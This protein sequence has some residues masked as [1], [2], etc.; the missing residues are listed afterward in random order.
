MEHTKTSPPTGSPNDGGRIYDNRKIAA[1]LYWG[2]GG[3]NN[4]FTDRN[5]GIV[6]TSLVLSE[7]YTGVPKGTNKPGY[8]ELMA[9]AQA[10]DVPDDTISFSS[11]SVNSSIVG[12]E[13]RSETIIFNGDVTNTVSFI[14]PAE[15]TFV[16]QT[17]AQT[18]TGGSVTIKGGDSFYLSAP[19]SYDSNYYS[20]ELKG[21][22]KGYA[23]ILYTM[24]NSSLQTLVKGGQSDSPSPISFTVHYEARE[25]WIEVSKAGNNTDQFIQGA[26]Y[27]ILDSSG[28]VVDTITTGANGK[29]KSKG[30]MPGDYSVTEVIAPPGYTIDQTAQ[31][32]T[33]I[34][35]ETSACT[36][37]NKVV[38]GRVNLKK[39]DTKTG[40][41]PQGSATLVG[42]KYGIYS[43][44]VCT[45]LIEELTIGSDL[46]ATSKP[47]E[48]GASRTVYVKETKA[49]TGY[50]IDPTVYPVVLSQEDAVTE[51]VLVNEIVKDEVITGNIELQ[52]F[53]SEADGESAMLHPEQGAEFTAYDEATG[54]QY[55]EPVTTDKNGHATFN[56]L[57]YG[58]Y[59][60]KQTKTP[61][62][63]IEVD[64]FRVNIN[65]NGTT[66]YYN[67]I[68]AKFTSLVK[69]I[70]VDEET[71]RTIPVANTTFKIRDLET[72][73]WVT[74]TVNY[75]AQVV[76]DEFKTNS[77]GELILPLPLGYGEYE[78]HE[79]AA[80]N[81]YVLS[82]EP[83]KFTVNEQN[84]TAGEIIEVT[85]SDRAQK[86]V[87]TLTK[88][89]DTLSGA[90]KEKTKY[91]DQ[92]NFIFNQKALKDAEFDFV[93]AEDIL[94]P[95]GTVRA[96]K[97]DVVGHGVT[98]SKG[99][100]KSP[101]LYLGQYYAV[102]TKAPAGMV[103]TG[104]QIPFELKYA[105][106][107]VAITST[108]V[109]AENVL[110]ELQILINKS[111][112]SVAYEN[113][114]TVV[115][116]T[117][118]NGKTFGVFARDAI[119]VD[120]EEIVPA[121]GLLAVAT[122]KEG[123]A[124]VKD[125]FPE[126]MYYVKELETSS[127]HDLNTN[128]YDFVFDATNNAPMV[129]INI[130][131]E[132]NKPIENKLHKEKLTLNKQNETIRYPDGGFSVDGNT[133]NTESI[134]VPGSGTVF[135]IYQ[136]DKLVQTI[137]I[138]EDGTATVDLYVGEYQL[139]E[140]KP[141]SNMVDRSNEVWNITVSKKGIEV[142]DSNHQV[143]D[144]KNDNELVV[145][146]YL[147]KEKLSIK[148]LNEVLEKQADEWQSHY[149]PTGKGTE[150]ELSQNG[151]LIK[152]ITM[153]ENSA[154]KLELPI[155]EYQL[156]EVAAS[157]DDYAITDE[158]WTIIVTSDGLTVTDSGGNIVA[159]E[160]EEL[161]IKN[162]LK[163]GEAEISK[164]EVGGSE[165]LPGAILNV[166][167]EDVDITWV[168]TNEPKK[169]RLKDG[170]YTLTE[171]LPNDGYALNTE[172]VT[173]EVKDGET[174]K[175]VMH[176]KRLPKAAATPSTGDQPT[177]E[178]VFV[179]LL[180]ISAFVLVALGLRNR[181][182]QQTMN[183]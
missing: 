141:S 160:N 52:K 103:L 38:L 98:D 149:E 15:I 13:Q 172:T 77:Q 110:Q 171:T 21:S 128:E 74:Q 85:F 121:N 37:T 113:G 62:G 162:N 154:A 147:H 97:G 90:E 148:K 89:G 93:A 5:Q 14:L 109:S 137:I 126:A 32:V 122:T 123:I 169:L 153:D 139:Q 69:I 10:E 112:E 65:E 177:V 107:E 124:Q 17:T 144:L 66:Q 145:K 8:K 73:E 23:P 19:L 35:N 4:I 64:D 135:G 116:S 48:I 25:G 115:T 46:T 138:G 83:V 2:W 174:T 57:P 120:G 105:G 129:T 34:P 84:Q 161:T 61:P 26:T 44:E 60:I 18:Q 50:N 36:F 111:E 22:M 180:G 166:K 58:W 88:T 159:H 27:N 9:H 33:V 56:A 130:A 54:K 63:M 29:A 157:T 47:F 94:T 86:G 168:S 67:M 3:T 68:N 136:D 39:E 165:E 42:A 51:V 6:V 163:Q 119:S 12:N 11:S 43:D 100:V 91:G 92:Y 133:D 95:D 170:S 151:D 182:K 108:A 102:E 16:N 78:L 99:Q 1:A 7:L 80:P 75:P 81:G 101:Q 127:A 150:F 152:T 167:G 96:K 31:N 173:F 178:I 24:T 132:N 156:K 146:N 28:T 40:S 117:P 134:Y 183:K 131:D 143:V 158:N 181:M 142:T 155:G 79:V 82:K 70:K 49:P 87:A 30:L 175:V 76:L 59:V 55:G 72:G 20:G 179:F 164:Q 140:L 71:G 176:N 45:Q 118:S 125:K 53:Y 104:E 106:E 114:Q 41:K